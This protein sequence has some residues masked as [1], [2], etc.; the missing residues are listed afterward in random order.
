M[1]RIKSVEYIITLLIA[2]PTQIHWTI[3]FPMYGINDN[4]KIQLRY[5]II[6]I[7]LNIIYYIY[8]F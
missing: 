6:L 1:N 4:I 3:E 5:Y 7:N 2:N 8:E